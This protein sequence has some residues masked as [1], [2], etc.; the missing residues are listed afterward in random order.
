MM[1]SARPVRRILVLALVIGIA[2]ALFRPAGRAVLG[3]AAAYT[4]TTSPHER[5]AA[6][7][8]VERIATRIPGV[9]GILAMAGADLSPDAIDRWLD[10]ASRSLVHA[11]AVR[12]PFT[13]TATSAGG[14]EAAAW[15]I[16]AR[17]GHRLVVT[18]HSTGAVFVD[19]IT[20]DGRHLAGAGP[21]D[22]ELSADADA[23]GDVILRLQ[24]PLAAAGTYRVSEQSTPSM[25][26]PVAGLTSRAVQSGF[27][28]E[29]DAG[30]RSHE[31]IDIFA[32]RGTAVLAATDGWIGASMSNG[33]GGNVVWVWA[34]ARHVRT[35]YAHL[36]RQA[37]APYE[38]VRSG[39]VIGYVGNT[40][41]ARGGPT[42]LH[43]GVYA[44]LGGSVD[45]LPFVC[46][47]ACDKR[48]GAAPARS[49][50]AFPRPA[51]ALANS[52]TVR[53]PRLRRSSIGITGGES[54]FPPS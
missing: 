15:R 53:R 19:L 29:R 43:F 32:P 23:D 16:P 9:V 44:D 22:R 36:D 42:H 40:G 46:G 34:P 5:Y 39:Q 51:C 17:R 24:P 38:R 47:G 50:L 1:P 3:I 35:Y 2:I 10:A 7:L 30:R 54:S 6:R 52:S 12:P 28:A 20:S 8:R 45:P 4:K 14:G 13:A 48:R 33:L 37:V 11:D 27:G 41:N 21:A 26:F 18:W 31:G 49:S 25:A